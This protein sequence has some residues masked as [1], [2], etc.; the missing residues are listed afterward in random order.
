MYT[1]LVDIIVNL[2]ANSMLIIVTPLTCFA[3]ATALRDRVGASL[4]FKLV[5]CGS[6]LFGITANDDNNNV[7]D[8]DMQ[9]RWTKFV[10]DVTE[11]VIT[12]ATQKTQRHNTAAIRLMNND[13]DVTQIMRILQARS[14]RDDQV[15]E[16]SLMRVIAC[17]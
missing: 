5:V 16:K 15:I 1:M 17:K 2:Q 4:I 13:D 14:S 3:L 7:Q 11:I 12:I 6:L 9:S 10:A 8:C